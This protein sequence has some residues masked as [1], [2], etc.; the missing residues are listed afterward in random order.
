[1]LKCLPPVWS[2]EGDV[3]T[4][5]ETIMHLVFLGVSQ[6]VGKVL[7]ETLTAFKLFRQFHNNDNELQ[8]IR[9]L[10]LDWCKTWIFGSKNTPFGPWVLENTLGYVCVMKHLY[11]PLNNIS[12]IM[13]KKIK[14]VGTV[15]GSNGVTNHAGKNNK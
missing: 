8:N 11:E 14:I 1:M 4:H 6:T 12:D 9:S 3:C 10:Q 15:F 7:K 2:T 13:V 5:I